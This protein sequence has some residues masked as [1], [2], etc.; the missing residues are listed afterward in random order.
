MN[1]SQLSTF[2]LVVLGGGPAG[3]SGALAAGLFGK[4]V[5]LVERA[6][7][8]GGAGIN[9]GTIPSKTLR[10]TALM[11]SGWRSRRLFGVDLSLRREATVSDFMCHEKQVTGSERQRV[12]A[13]LARRGVV[14]F[15][16]AASFLD[17]HTIKMV[18]EDGAETLIRGE[19]IL[20]ATGSSP[21][22]P[23][24]FPFEDD[25]V[26]DS[27][28]ILEL[29]ALPKKLIVVGGGVIGSE[30]A[31]TFAALGAEVHLVDGRDT[32]MP[33]LD[34]E[35]SRGLAE[36]M[37]ANGVQFHWKEKV[38]KCDATQQGD[39]VLTLSSGATLAGDGVLVCAGRSSNTDTLNLA[40]A[41]L[42]PGKRG[43]VVV[44]AHYRSAVPHIYAAGDVVGPPALAATSVEQARV[45][46][47]HAFD[48][49]VKREIAP[50]LPVGIYTIPEASMAGET[51]APTFSRCRWAVCRSRTL[52]RPSA[53]FTI[54]R[55]RS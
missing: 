4:T 20:I 43:L 19:K 28:E 21:L 3:T 36:A 54:R 33:F 34:A 44:D 25:R 23:P 17:A 29:K 32:L 18:G 12:E 31:G 47:C 51:M 38:V 6:A 27:N 15:H 39:V 49:G 42:T 55:N 22:R 9:T 7:Q 46:I 52:Q 2:D 53:P 48:I 30:Y 10:E 14:R 45:A 37:T 5:A 40:A 1:S 50:I 8:L 41:G 35:I 11:L 16:G 13:R 26:H 24:E